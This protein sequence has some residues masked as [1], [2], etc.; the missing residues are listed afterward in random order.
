VVTN[1]SKSTVRVYVPAL[2]CVVEAARTDREAVPLQLGVAPRKDAGDWVYLREGEFFGRSHR[3]GGSGAD[4]RPL[5]FYTVFAASHEGHTESI[6]ATVH[7]DG[8]VSSPA[9]R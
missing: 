5:A 8:R 9:R 3:L 2:I 4:R 6:V 1:V 7:S